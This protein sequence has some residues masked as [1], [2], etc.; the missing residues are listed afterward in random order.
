VLSLWDLIYAIVKQHKSFTHVLH[1][2]Q[3]KYKLSQEM[4]NIY[5]NLSKGSLVEWFIGI[6]ELKHGVKQSI[7]KETTYIGGAQHV[8]ILSKFPTLEKEIIVL[9]K[10]HQDASQPLYVT[11]V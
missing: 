3:L 1:Y 11:I 6:G 5:E 10:A 9:L 4:K 8:Y 7:F 2:L